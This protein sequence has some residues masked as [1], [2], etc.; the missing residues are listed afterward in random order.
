[1]LEP[2]DRHFLHLLQDLLS[3]WLRFL[4]YLCWLINLSPIHPSMN[5]HKEEEELMF[6]I[7]L[8]YNK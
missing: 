8:L 5:P 1:M 2:D 6:I 4:K 3:L 7:Y